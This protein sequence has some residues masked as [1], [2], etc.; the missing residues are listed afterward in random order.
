[1][2]GYSPVPLDPLPQVQSTPVEAKTAAPPQ[3]LPAQAG[4]TGKGGQTANILANFLQGWTAGKNMAEEKK[5]KNMQGDINASWAAYQATTEDA[6]NISK[7]PNSTDEQKKAAQL[8]RSQAWDHWVETH[9][10]YAQPEK[11]KKGGSSG[12]SGSGSGGTGSKKQQQGGGVG[13]VLARMFL[14]PKPTT[15]EDS[16]TWDLMG[17]NGP[18]A[19][20]PP[21]TQEKEAQF[22]LS[23]EKKEVA[24]R[25]EYSTLLK[26]TDRT[27][28]EQKRLEGLEDE[29]FGPGSADK[30]KVAHIQ[31]SEMQQTQKDTDAAREKYK[32]GQ[33]LNER[34]RTLLE[35]AGELPKVD[36]KTPF[37]AYAKEVGPG[38]KFKTYSEAAD[39][40][41]AKEI[42]VQ[43]ASRNPSMW[44]EMTQAGNDVLKEQFAKDDANPEKPHT[45]R[46]TIGGKTEERQMTDE[47]AKAAQAQDKNLKIQKIPRVPTKGDVFGWVAERMKP[48]PEETADAKAKYPKPKNP[49]EMAQAMSPVFAT[50]IQ[51]NP[52]WEKFIAKKQ[53]PGGG[54]SMG[55]NPF[56]SKMV[57]FFERESTVKK[58]YDDFLKAVQNEMIRRGYGDL[59]PKVLPMNDPVSMEMTPP[60]GQ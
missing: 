44:E 54:V 47:Q 35:N 40:Y 53:T 8:K 11:P 50:V 36:V 4:W 17:K 48:S 33:Q 20:E 46:V 52:D 22:R 10:K 25:D 32:A 59:I 19:L 23:E 41:Y 27:P 43:K 18:P 24:K 49:T 12:G 29:M 56:S 30:S 55:L 3:P 14:A 16:S 34:E 9:K 1:M 51:D 38:K 60:P 45:Y 57:G 5:I 39:A 28:D 7:D 15:G 37:E 2:G 31:A 21:S 42:S 6:N 26:K 58:N 13:D